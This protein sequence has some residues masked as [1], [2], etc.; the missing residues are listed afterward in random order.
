ML[1]NEPD[2]GAA[3]GPDGAP[4]DDRAQLAANVM[5]D[6][7]AWWGTTLQR[8]RGNGDLPPA[9]RRQMASVGARQ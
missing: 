2:V 3:F 6:D 8:A 4:V 7:L 9:I 1:S 5:L